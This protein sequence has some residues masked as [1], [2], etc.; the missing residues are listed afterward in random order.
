ML[1]F[2]KAR[3]LTSLTHF[4]NSILFLVV[5]EVMSLIAFRMDGVGVGREV[6]RGC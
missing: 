3:S 1:V 6:G 5:D 2:I 4:A